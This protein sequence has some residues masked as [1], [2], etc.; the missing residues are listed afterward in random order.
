MKKD[1]EDIDFKFESG[2]VILEKKISIFEAIFGGRIEVNTIYGI[3]II[4]V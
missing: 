3:Q 1:E 4:E 2:N